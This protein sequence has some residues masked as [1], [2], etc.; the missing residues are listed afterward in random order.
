M[1]APSPSLQDHPTVKQRKYPNAE[2][3]EVELKI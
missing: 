3:A 2:K 1:E